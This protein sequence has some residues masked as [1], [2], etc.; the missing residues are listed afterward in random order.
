MKISERR[1]FLQGKL[2]LEKIAQE[3][4]HLKKSYP[5][6]LNITPE[7]IPIEKYLALKSL[8]RKNLGKLAT[9][10]KILSEK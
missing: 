7:K 3:K 10:T 4:P 8:T 2:T 6:T 5:K 9:R 1:Q